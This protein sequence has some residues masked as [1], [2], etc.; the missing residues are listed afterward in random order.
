MQ[1]AQLSTELNGRL[2]MIQG[3]LQRVRQHR[4]ADLD[5]LA[6][7]AAEVKQRLFRDLVGV[8]LK[9]LEE[10]SDVTTR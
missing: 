7:K 6:T 9:A 1:K 2:K 4:D 8:D 5:V 3:D 10:A